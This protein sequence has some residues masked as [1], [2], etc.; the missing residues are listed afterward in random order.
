MHAGLSLKST[1]QGWTLAELLIGLA[2]M[3][4]LMALAFPA[5]QQQ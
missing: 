4:M 5:Y 2:L 1:C 3:S